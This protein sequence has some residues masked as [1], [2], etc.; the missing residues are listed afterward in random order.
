MGN[1]KELA[2]FMKPKESKYV[3]EGKDLKIGRGVI[4]CDNAIIPLDAV[5]FIET[6]QYGKLG[7][8]RW[9]YALIAGF[10]MIFIPA[11]IIIG[12]LVFIIALVNVI[13]IY[14]KNKQTIY[15]L[16]IQNHAGRNFHIATSD[17][18]FLEEMRKALLTCMNDKSVSYSGK[19]RIWMINGDIVDGDKFSAAGDINIGSNRN[20]GTIGSSDVINGQGRKNVTNSNVVLD[21]EWKILEEFAKGRMKDFP[22]N[23]RNFIICKNLAIC[24]ERKDRANSQSLLKKAGKAALEIILASAPMAVK[25]VI[26]KLM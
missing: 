5:S 8:G 15:Y 4:V 7:Y 10:I 3:L 24:A 20:S 17:L 6:L 16:N 21:E 9:P 22:Q 13:G 23:E 1:L 19:E 2:D 25:A 12:I 11:T 26:N 18:D 14:Q